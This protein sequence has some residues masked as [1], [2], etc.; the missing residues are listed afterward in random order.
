[1]NCWSSFFHVNAL[2]VLCN[3]VFSNECWLAGIF[4]H[5]NSPNGTIEYFFII[6]KH[7]VSK[8]LKKG[9]LYE[10]F[11]QISYPVLL[12]S[13]Y[14]NFCDTLNFF[15]WQCKNETFWVI[16]KHCVSLFLKVLLKTGMAWKYH[17]SNKR[18]Q[19]LF[20][21]ILGAPISLNCSTVN[22]FF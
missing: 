17:W 13:K 5:Q 7:S 1:M 19:T 6:F 9:Y 15:F 12:A 20:R 21:H 18:S 10:T 14:L 22:G 11:S 8:S 2:Y 4:Q 16:F 3:A